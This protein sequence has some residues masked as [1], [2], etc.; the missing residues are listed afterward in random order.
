VKK[1]LWKKALIQSVDEAMEHLSGDWRRRSYSLP[2]HPY[3]QY[4]THRNECENDKN[5]VK[6]ILSLCSTN[7]EIFL[8]LNDHMFIERLKKKYLEET[9]K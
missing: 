6:N 9:P 5:R 8:S 2:S 7:N 1:G 3:W 4:V